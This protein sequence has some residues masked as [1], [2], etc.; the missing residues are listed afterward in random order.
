LANIRTEEIIKTSIIITKDLSII[1]IKTIS[2]IAK[3]A[4][5]FS[6]ETKKRRTVVPHREVAYVHRILPIDLK[7]PQIITTIIIGHLKTPQI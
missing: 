1:I 6:R 2:Q 5:G 4:I 7:Q 3:M